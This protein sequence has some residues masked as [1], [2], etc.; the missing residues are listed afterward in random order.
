MNKY[1][2]YNGGVELTTISADKA[3]HD[4]HTGITSFYSKRSDNTTVY[5]LVAVVPGSYLIAEQST[6]K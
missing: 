5:R 1:K 6:T 2:I 3:K 4:P